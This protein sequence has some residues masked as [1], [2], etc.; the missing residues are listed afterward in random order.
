MLV[1]TVLSYCEWM[2]LSSD[3]FDNIFRTF[4][5]VVWFGISK[6]RP[7]SF[8]ELRGILGSGTGIFGTSTEDVAV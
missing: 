7:V 1:W 6:F 4:L 5:V 3:L 8:P 2:L